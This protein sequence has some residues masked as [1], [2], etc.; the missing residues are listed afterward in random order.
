MSAPDLA[1]NIET[2]RFGGPA[3]PI[4]H[5]HCRT[6]RRSLP[7][8]GSTRFAREDRAML[9]LTAAV[10]A[11]A[12]LS[13]PAYAAPCRDAHGKFV[14]CTAA[15][16]PKKPVRCKDAKGKFAKCGLPGTH[17]V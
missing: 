5:W 3:L 8:A 7:G 1:A 10:A 4:V 17:K 11:I 15:A 12:L 14:K 16:A 6:R 2:W 9:K 13:A